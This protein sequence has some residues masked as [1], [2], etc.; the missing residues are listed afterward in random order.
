MTS[1]LSLS[2]LLLLKCMSK[3]N[4]RLFFFPFIP[5]RCG[6]CV[7]LTGSCLLSECLIALSASPSSYF[8]SDFAS[9]C[10]EFLDGILE[11]RRIR[12]SECRSSLELLFKSRCARQKEST[13]A[14][15]ACDARSSRSAM[16][17]RG[18][19][20][21]GSDLKSGDRKGGTGC[22]DARRQERISSCQ[23]C[24]LV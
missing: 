2:L 7:R 22:R 5:C 12:W 13:S 11:K 9:K 18:E 19:T 3:S 14:E 1:S 15:A 23:V 6:T 4:D 10:I 21:S 16:T 24:V 20:R 8:L 17:T